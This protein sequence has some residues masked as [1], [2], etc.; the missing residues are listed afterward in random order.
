[1]AILGTAWQA[2]A[3]SPLDYY[4]VP[5][6]FEATFPGLVSEDFEDANLGGADSQGFA[7]PLDA[8]TSNGVFAP[9]AIPPGVVFDVVGLGDLVLAGPG[10]DNFGWIGFPSQNL[11]SGTNDGDSIELRFPAGT[12]AVGLRL[13]GETDSVRVTTRGPASVVGNLDIDAPDASRSTGIFL[14]IADEDPIVSVTVNAPSGGLFGAFEAIDD[15]RFEPPLAVA[16][17]RFRFADVGGAVAGTFSYPTAAGGPL[18]IGDNATFTIESATGDLAA[19][20]GVDWNGGAIFSAGGKVSVGRS[21]L[22]TF[23]QFGFSAPFELATPIPVGLFTQAG[24]VAYFGDAPLVTGGA[25]GATVELP[26][27]GSLPSALAALAA[28]A[29]LCRSARTRAPS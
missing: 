13:F 2:R 21:D 3:V 26:A 15:V 24:S 9:G 22:D 11:Q 20:L 25:P 4:F 16:R 5:E 14:G 27:P 23:F 28:L 1:M 29:A 18:T 8:T 17:Y 7:A 6:V 19:Y 10:Y 12:H